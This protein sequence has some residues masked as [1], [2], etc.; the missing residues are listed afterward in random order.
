MEY[1]RKSDRKG[2]TH[3]W[4]DKK[5]RDTRTVPVARSNHHVYPF[6][7]STTWIFRIY[8]IGRTGVEIR[9]E[10]FIAPFE[11]IFHRWYCRESSTSSLEL[12][13]FVVNII[14]SFLVPSNRELIK[15]NIYIYIKIL[16]AKVL[17]SKER[18]QFNRRRGTCKRRR[19]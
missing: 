4:H 10:G 11:T 1:R 14:A 5:S 8:P 15:K 6:D 12:P 9:R 7:S 16:R 3:C 17:L 19:G 13:I 2:K 18:S